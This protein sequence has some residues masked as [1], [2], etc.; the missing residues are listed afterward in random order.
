MI[1][2]TDKGLVVITGCAHPNVT[3][4][5]QHAKAYLGKDIYL[6]MGG[7]HLVANSDAAIEAI[8]TQLQTLGVQKI[9]PSHC[10]GEKA[11]SMFRAAWGNN[12]IDGGLGAVIEV[13]HKQ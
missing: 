2:D 6:L 4:M 10:T 13:T 3:D 7:F 9:A 12:F 8:V 5:A 11:I 1:A